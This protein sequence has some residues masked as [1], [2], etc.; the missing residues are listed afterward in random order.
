MKD[1]PSGH[2][3][4]MEQAACYQAGAADAGATVDGDGSP[5]LKAVVQCAYQLKQLGIRCWDA[6]IS[7][8]ELQE[9]DALVSAQHRLLVEVQF[10][11]FARLEE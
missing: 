8:G 9:F 10:P 11:D 1:V 5:L 3:E 6:A 4:K 2:A 7:D